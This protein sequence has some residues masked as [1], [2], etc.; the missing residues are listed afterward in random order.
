MTNHNQ[1]K[2]KKKPTSDYDV[3]YA[4][5]P[6]HTQFQPG[7]SGN[8]KG[9]AKGTKNL[10]TDLAEELRELIPVRE[11]GGRTR[12]LT[13]QRAMVKAILNKTLQ[14]DTRSANII[15]SMMMRLIDTGADATEPQLPLNQD[16]LQVL[17]DFVR[18]QTDTPD[19]DEKDKENES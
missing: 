3:G 10:K 1:S 9:R 8:P 14:G 11:R 19:T 2:G 7:K 18:R 12:K 5:P 13:K 6:R 16:E 17:E 15:L 4:R